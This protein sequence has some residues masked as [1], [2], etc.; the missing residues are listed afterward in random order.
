M[1]APRPLRRIASHPEPESRVHQLAGNHPTD[2]R[3]GETLIRGDAGFGGENAAS[4]VDKPVGLRGS[5]SQ[6]ELFPQT[7]AR[8]PA[9]VSPAVGA[10]FSAGLGVSWRGVFSTS[11]RI[12]LILFQQNTIDFVCR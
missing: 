8:S 3:S 7:S 9:R 11:P 12:T 4:G 2:T 5:V 1:C 6:V 10:L